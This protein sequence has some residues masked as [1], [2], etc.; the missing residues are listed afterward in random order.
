MRLH[1]SPARR[2]RAR[3]LA[4]DAGSG[5]RRARRRAWR[6]PE[7]QLVSVGGRF[8]GTSRLFAVRDPAPPVWWPRSVATAASPATPS[9]SS[10]T[11]PD[12]VAD[13]IAARPVAHHPG[14]GSDAA[15]RRPRTASG[16]TSRE[17]AACWCSAAPTSLSIKASAEGKPAADPPREPQPARDRGAP[18]EPTASDR[19]LRRTGEGWRGRSRAGLPGRPDFW[20]SLLESGAMSAG[21]CR[22]AQRLW[23]SSPPCPKSLPKSRRPAEPRFPR[24]AALRAE[25]GPW[26]AALLYAGPLLVFLLIAMLPLMRGIGDAHPARRAQL[27]L[28]HEVVAGRGD[29]ARDFPTPRPLPGRRAAAGGQPQRRAVLSGQPAVPRAARSSG[30]STPASGSTCS[31]RRSPSTGWPA[32]GGSDAQAVLGGGGLLDGLRLLPLAPQLLQPDRRRDPGAG[33]GRRRPRL[34]PP[35]RP[36]RPAG[37]GSS[38]CSGRC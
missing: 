17:T 29:A 12:P 20:L 8:G 37:A 28:P 26:R 36:A 5:G 19:G 10:A 38:P 18:R 33:P 11:A 35:C 9:A 6:P 30:R 24:L 22:A 25:P 34:P 1:Y 7:L 21:W 23:Y 13:V 27:A 3:Q 14:A 32:P 16:S 2:R 31:S 4:A 15:P